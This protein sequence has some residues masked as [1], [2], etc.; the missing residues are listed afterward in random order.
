MLDDACIVIY[1]LSLRE[2]RRHT[3]CDMS[4]VV[5]QDDAWVYDGSCASS[6]L[7]IRAGCSCRHLVRELG[8]ELGGNVASLAF[9]QA[10]AS[11]HYGQGLC[12]YATSCVACSHAWRVMGAALSSKQGLEQ[13]KRAWRKSRHGCANI[14]ASQLWLVLLRVSEPSEVDVASSDPAG[15]SSSGLVETVLIFTL[16]PKRMQ[17]NRLA[18]VSLAPHRS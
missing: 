16:V 5:C 14:A 13:G 3:G 12:G 9:A 2:D 7:P 11:F 8:L 1:G 10:L 6:Q 17:L 15:C 18:G 4:E